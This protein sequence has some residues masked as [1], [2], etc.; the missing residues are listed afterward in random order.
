[1]RFNFSLSTPRLRHKC[2]DTATEARVASLRGH[3]ADDDRVKAKTAAIAVHGKDQLD[4]QKEEI[5]PRPLAFGIVEA[6][7][8]IEYLQRTDEAQK[9]TK[10]PRISETAVS[11]SRP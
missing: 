10:M 7:P 1:M 3:P 9:R 8:Q 11:T 2:E 5:G 6:E 4:H